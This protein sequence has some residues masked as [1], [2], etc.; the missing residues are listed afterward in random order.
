MWRSESPRGAPAASMDP[1]AGNSA[2]EPALTGAPA[3]HHGDAQYL[4]TMFCG[5]LH[6]LRIIPPPG[7]GT[8]GTGPHGLRRSNNIAAS[9]FLATWSS[10]NFTILSRRDRI[11]FSS[12][13]VS[14]PFMVWARVGSSNFRRAAKS[15]LSHFTRFLGSLKLGIIRNA[16]DLSTN[17]SFQLLS[18]R[19]F[20]RLGSVS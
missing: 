10:N 20:P 18:I 14:S 16:R 1:R 17:H 7:P 3:A 4:F 15:D 19:K 12:A 13:F 5:P 2:I 11:A 6:R 9:P 8:I